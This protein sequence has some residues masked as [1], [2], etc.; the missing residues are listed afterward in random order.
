M[1]QHDEE[2]QN[3]VQQ[4]ATDSSEGTAGDLISSAPVSRVASET[5]M[6]DETVDVDMEMNVVGVVAGPKD[7]MGFLQVPRPISEMWPAMTDFSSYLDRSAESSD[8]ERDIQM[9]DTNGYLHIPESP[10]VYGWN[11][12]W[13]RLQPGNR[14]DPLTT[15]NR[16]GRKVGKVSLLQRVLSVGRTTAVTRRTGFTG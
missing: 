10:D 2:P 4:A 15:R 13:D 14:V 3:E 11:A 8:D 12:D 1:E 7:S 16:G 9:V 6:S 5:S